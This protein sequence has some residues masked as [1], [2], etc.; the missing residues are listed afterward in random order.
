[1][2]LKNIFFST[3]LAAGRER[4]ILLLAGGEEERGETRERRERFVEIA[5]THGGKSNFFKSSVVPHHHVCLG[6]WREREEREREI[7]RERDRLSEKEI[8]RMKKKR[9]KKERERKRETDRVK[10]K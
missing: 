5:L 9:E 8:E 10:R 6:N 2:R 1:L 3:S 7:D 4:E